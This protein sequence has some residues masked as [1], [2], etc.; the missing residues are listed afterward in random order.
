MSD[1]TYLCPE[2]GKELKA[3]VL[4]ADKGE[5]E[6]LVLYTCPDHGERVII[7]WDE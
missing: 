6:Q 2:C 4:D 1:V 7:R 3:E 5:Q